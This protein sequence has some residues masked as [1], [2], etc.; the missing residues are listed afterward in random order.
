[1]GFLDRVRCR[2]T[3]IL[4]GGLQWTGFIPRATHTGVR[5]DVCGWGW[6][7]TQAISNFFRNDCDKLGAVLPFP[8]AVRAGYVLS[9]GTSYVLLVLLTPYL[10][11]ITTYL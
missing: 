9:A 2:H 11:L 10:L 8:Y 7:P 6:A 1:M 5:G 4:L 3:H